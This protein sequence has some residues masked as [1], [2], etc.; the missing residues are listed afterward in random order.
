[1]GSDECQVTSD[2]LQISDQRSALGIWRRLSSFPALLGALLVAAVFVAERAFYVDPDVWWH[3]KVGESILQTHRFPT[4]D[5]YSFTVPGSPWMAYEWLGEV[6]LAVV[7]RAGGLRGLLALEIV[8][9][10]AV[11]LALYAL[12]TQRSGN[13]KAAFVAC[14]LMLLLVELSFTLRP[15][16]I[17]YLFLVLTLIAL[18]RFRQGK[19]GAL[20]LLP[21]L[22]L[23][24][25]NTHGS[26]II[27]LGVMAVYWTSGLVEFGGGLEARRW[28]PAQRQRLAFVF[29]LCLAALVV[30]PYGTRIAVYPLD[31][32]LGQ[33]L[34]VASINEWQSMPFN[35]WFGKLFLL[36]LIAFLVAQIALRPTWRLEEFALFL[37]G[38]VMACLHARFV[39]VFVPF[40]APLLAVL[41]ARWVPRYEWAK[42]KHVLNAVLMALVV[43]GAVR[44]FPPLAKLGALVGERYPANAVQ[45]VR[46]NSVPGPM[47]NNYTFGGYL[48]YALGPEHKVF[49]DGRAD[50]YERGGV[51][52]D[53][54]RISGVQPEA[55]ALLKAYQVRSCLL[56]RGEA[57]GTLLAASGDWQQVYGDKVSVLFVRRQ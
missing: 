41:L 50:V 4:A 28:T 3:L 17:G 38:T 2:E 44:F 18:E 40:F 12:A 22:F 52:A 33:P 24:W 30:T 51:L 5:P 54:G 45:F 19:P 21:P 11:A 55:P 34:N 6:L 14:A 10:A 42:D 26:F 20:W 57:L 7:A 32:A 31:M 25:V 37:V 27:G 1:M 8:L 15:Q 16:M 56:E 53:Y 35:L 43:T 29:L 47:Y 36:L 13:S 39:L 48:I 23:V 9:G 49:I 46:A